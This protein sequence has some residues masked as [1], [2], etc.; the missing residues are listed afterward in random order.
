MALTREQKEEMAHHLRTTNAT[1]YV[2]TDEYMENLNLAQ[3]QELELDTREGKTK[4]YVFTAKNRTANCPVHINIH[5][6]GFVRAHF[7]RDEIYSAILADGIGGIVVDID[8]KLA[9]E[10]PFPTA[11]NECYDVCRWV[12]TQLSDWDAD[13]NRVS[14]GGHSAGGNLTA[15]IALEANRTK[16]FKLCLQV[17][18]Y[19]ALDMATDPELK[20]EAA[21]NNISVERG[22]MFNLCYTDGNT[23][24]LKDLRVSPALAGDELLAGLP[25]ALVITA[26]YDNFR[27][28]AETYAARLVAAGVTVTS[29]RYLESYHGFTVAATGAY[30]EAQKLIIRAINCA[31][32]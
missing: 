17:I 1:T 8:Y 12:F 11:Y 5:G 30:V 32:L 13:I 23:E 21:T 18:D 3:R 7:V 26:G 28:E 19:G 6:G 24:L 20:P 15:A 14:L 16:D 27:F 10:H 31:S 25:E 22:R 4:V 9:P 29:K 2:L